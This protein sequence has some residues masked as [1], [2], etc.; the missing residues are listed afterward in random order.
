M[1]GKASEGA[2]MDDTAQKKTEFLASTFFTAAKAGVRQAG[3]AI[4]VMSSSDMRLDVI[5]AGVSP[6]ARLSDF[7]GSPEDLVIGVYI[8]VTGEVPGHALLVIPYD[9]ALRLVDM[10]L[11]LPA[12]TTTRVDEMAASV[13]QEAGN[14]VTASYLKA[15]S[16][17]FGWTL[18]PSPPS[19]AIDMAAAVVDSVLLSTGHFDDETISIVTKFSG[20]KQSMRGFFLYIPEAQMTMEEAA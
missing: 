12:N 20:R 6:T 16:D 3:E 4:S 18:L 7:A 19:L 8:Q 1:Q 17:F 13:L 14:I 2:I 10:L 15:L 5:S 9:G 11:G